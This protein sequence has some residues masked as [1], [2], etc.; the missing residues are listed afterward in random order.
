VTPQITEEGTIY[1]DVDVENTQIDTG[2]PRV[3]GIPALDT[4]EAQTK[5]LVTDGGTVVIGG[6]IV[7]SQQTSIDQTPLLGSI[8]IIGHLFRHTT[9]T[10]SSQELLFFITPRIIPS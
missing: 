8:P 4:Q 1:M 5:V 2:I 9:V 3:Q 10:S 7:S 6:V